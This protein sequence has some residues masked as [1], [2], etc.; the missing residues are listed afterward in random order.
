MNQRPAISTGHPYVIGSMV[1]AVGATVFVLVNRGLLPDPW[2]LVALVAWV[3]ALGAYV[4]RV[5]LSPADSLPAG[6]QPHPRGWLIY[7]AS[8]A[9]MILAIQVGRLLLAG[10]DREGL[11]PALIAAA[12]GL[13]F[14]PFATAFRAPLF[15]TLGLLV[16]GLGLVGLAVGWFAGDTVAAAAAV[17]SGLVMLVTMTL[18]AG[19]R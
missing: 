2:P 12:V 5:L 16:G 6:E 9:G 17:L 18:G 4:W 11:G 10:A 7:L 3:L 14:L 13:H 15:R 1:G 8:V 19:R